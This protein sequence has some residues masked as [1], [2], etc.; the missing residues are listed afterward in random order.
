MHSLQKHGLVKPES[1]NQLLSA[2]KRA[3]ARI[4]DEVAATIGVS[5]MFPTG[6]VIPLHA[7]PAFFGPGAG[8]GPDIFDGGSVAFDIS[9]LMIIL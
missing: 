3:S 1:R 5:V 9:N 4:G 6:G 2:N 7:Y 8:D